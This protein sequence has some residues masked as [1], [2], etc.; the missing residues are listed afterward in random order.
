MTLCGGIFVRG[1]VYVVRLMTQSPHRPD[2]LLHYT[3]FTSVSLTEAL[4]MLTLET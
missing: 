2:S 4:F 3:K 1:I